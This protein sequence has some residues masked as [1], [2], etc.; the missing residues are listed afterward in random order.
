MGN[1][2]TEQ[3][4]KQFFQ[5]RIVHKPEF[6]K[7]IKIIETSDTN[8]YYFKIASYPEKAPVLVLETIVTLQKYFS[9]LNKKVIKKLFTLI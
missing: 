9:L 1:L 5:D 6:K 2:F 7:A 4:V 8:K 3:T